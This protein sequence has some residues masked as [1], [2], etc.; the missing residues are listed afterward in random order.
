MH[1][2][3]DKNG[4]YGDTDHFRAQLEIV[5]KQSRAQLAADLA[6]I[7]GQFPADVLREP[8]PTIADVEREFGDFDRML[9]PRIEG[10]AAADSL[11]DF[12]AR[13]EAIA[14]PE[15][16]AAVSPLPVAPATPAAEVDAITPR[17]QSI[18][19]SPNFH[20]GCQEL[21][22]YLRD[23]FKLASALPQQLGARIDYLAHPTDLAEYMLARLGRPASEADAL[24]K[25]LE[26]L[27]HPPLVIHMSG[28][29][30]AVYAGGLTRHASTSESAWVDDRSHAQIIDQLSQQRLGHGLIDA[31]TDLGAIEQARGWWKIDVWRRMGKDPLQ[32]GITSDDVARHDALSAE[33]RFTRAGWRDYI[34]ERTCARFG[35][36]VSLSFRSVKEL[37]Q[38]IW[39]L[40]GAVVLG[41]IQSVCKLLMCFCRCVLL[42]GSNTADAAQLNTWMMHL[43]NANNVLHRDLEAKGYEDLGAWIGRLMLHKIEVTTST[44]NVP[45]AV[46]LALH[47]NVG[48]FSM[49]ADKMLSEWRK[50]PLK[51]PDTRL[52]MLCMLRDVSIGAPE[53]LRRVARNQWNM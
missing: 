39:G 45:Q 5:E 25:H 43:H 17:S 32:Y 20:A 7:V 2:N 38:A 53:D 11:D 18:F 44:I 40:S 10:G 3:S 4:Y 8:V 37:F 6:A 49:P 19:G 29:G 48:V 35:R 26:G 24:T 1:Q 12:A 46:M 15:R 22:Y 16:R 52:A 30:S 34:T 9:A 13:L 36:P 14:H 23:T 33:S 51:N 27:A 28:Y 21:D 31:C 42:P 41:P 47:D 50:E